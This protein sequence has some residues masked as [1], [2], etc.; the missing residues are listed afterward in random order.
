MINTRLHWLLVIVLQKGRHT[1]PNALTWSG[2]V[3]HTV[4]SHTDKV[5]DS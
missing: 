2:S 3:V 1:Q 4:S 5:F